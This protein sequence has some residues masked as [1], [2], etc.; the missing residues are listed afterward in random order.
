MHARIP[1]FVLAV[2]TL[3]G[4]AASILAVGDY[5]TVVWAAVAGAFAL[6]MLGWALSEPNPRTSL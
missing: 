2:I 6:W 5:R 4:L 3:V 1:L